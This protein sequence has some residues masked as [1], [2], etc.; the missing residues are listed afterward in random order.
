MRTYSVL[1]ALGLVAMILL[2]VVLSAAPTVASTIEADQVKFDPKLFRLD[3]P[4]PVIAHVKFAQPY[5][6]NVT[7]VDPATVLLEGL[8]APVATWTTQ[9]PPEFVAQFDG[10]LVASVLWSK[11][12]HMGITTPKPWVPTKIELRISGSLIDGTAWQGT[13]EIKI[14]IPSNDAS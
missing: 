14:L 12:Y 8:I 9:A 1:T 4:D 3:T 10:H 6:R 11:I 7:E 2:G 5:E 13:G